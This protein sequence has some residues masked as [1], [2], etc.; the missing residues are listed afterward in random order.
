MG[1]PFMAEAA[2]VD[3][4]L[5][6]RSAGH[7]T[8]DQPILRLRTRRPDSAARWNIKRSH[9]VEGPRRPI[10][11]EAV[12]ESSLAATGACEPYA[13]RFRCAECAGPEC[14]R[15]RDLFPE[16]PAAEDAGHPAPP[17]PRPGGAPAAGAA[18]AAGTPAAG[19][20]R[21]CIDLS[22]GEGCKAL[23]SAMPTDQGGTG[24]GLRPHRRSPLVRT[25]RLLA[26]SRVLHALCAGGAGGGAA[27]ARY[28]AVLC[29]AGSAPSN[30]CRKWNASSVR[31][32]E[33]T[34]LVPGD[35]P[36]APGGAGGGGWAAGVGRLEPL[37]LRGDD[38]DLVDAACM[39]GRYV[40]DAKGEIRSLG[41]NATRDGAPAATSTVTAGLEAAAAAVPEP[42]RFEGWVRGKFSGAA[43]GRGW[44]ELF[45]MQLFEA[46]IVEGARVH[47]N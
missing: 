9:D 46:A 44:A 42:M 37:S 4:S 32:L 18:G 5:R 31:E 11:C 13:P 26:C 15:T 23:A 28:A 35:R 1:F 33:P 3:T 27:C 34:D 2:L 22:C 24:F 6:N 19:C 47:R 38:G 16:Y 12:G 30:W 14:E 20:A 21:C 41:E 45:V 29:E 25:G 40:R 36:S 39:L 43:D 10:L 7:L 17:Q 8:R